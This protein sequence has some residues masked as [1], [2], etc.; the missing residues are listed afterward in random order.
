MNDDINLIDSE[1][2]NPAGEPTLLDNLILSEPELDS[3]AGEPPL[4]HRTPPIIPAV[5]K[6]TTLPQE[7]PAPLQQKLWPILIGLFA[8]LL[9]Q[10]TKRAVEMRIPLYSSVSPFPA[11]EETYPL[12]GQFFQ[13][14]HTQNTGAAFGILQN[15]G[16]IF[17]VVAVIVVVVIL[18]YNWQ[19][20]AGQLLLRT[21]LGLQLGGA[22]GNLIDRLRQGYVTD[23]FNLDFRVFVDI[24]GLEQILNWPIFNIADM[25]IVGGVII[26]AVLMVFESREE[27]KQAQAPIVQAPISQSPNLQSPISQSPIPPITHEPTTD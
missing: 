5:I 26:L 8:I 25:S 9:D 19:I 17:T 27:Q 16:A 11:L 12:L 22:L 14:T 7:P 2:D 24:E 4:P 23:F 13:L 1:P 15:G 6:Q 10:W 21:A 20:P 3:P 18:F